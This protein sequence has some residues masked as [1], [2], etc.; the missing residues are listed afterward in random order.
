MSTEEFNKMFSKKLRYYL[1]KYNMTQLD[2][3]K[4]LGVGTTSVYNWCNAIKT[5]RMDKV[6]AMCEIFNCNRSD[7]IED[8]EIKKEAKTENL[9]KNNSDLDLDKII[10][11]YKNMSEEGKKL[12]VKQAEFYLKEYPDT[13]TNERAI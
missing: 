10:D 4:R 12:L 13:K 3:S 6:D 9:K 5:P 7:L 8:K 1:E 2:L 11:C